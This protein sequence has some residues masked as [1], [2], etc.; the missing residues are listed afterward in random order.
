[1][2]V[3]DNMSDIDIA[4]KVKMKDIMVVAKSLGIE[5]DYL[6]VYGKY[7]AK[8]KFDEM[9]KSKNG[10]LILVTAI[11]PTP[12]GEGKTTV[13]IGLH[14]ALRRNGADSVAVLREPSLGPVFGMKGGATGGGYSQ[15]IPMEDINLHFTG[16]LHAITSANNLIS[17]AIDNHLHFGN[18]LGI[19]VSTITF[20]RCLDINDRALRD[21]VVSGFSEITRKE[22]FDITAASEVMSVFCLSK[23]LDDL[24]N[25]LGNIIVA[26]NTNGR[27]VYVKDLKL[28]GSLVV[29]LKDALNPNLVQ[30]LEN[31]PVII[32]GGPFANIAHGCNSII[33]TKLG[34]QLSDY[35]VTEAGFGADLGAEK[36]FDIKCRKAGLK[37][38]CVVLVATIRALKYNGGVD[39]NNINNENVEALKLGL[40][41]LLVHV[42]NLKKY[43]SNIIVALNRF[44]TDSEEE[45][46]IVKE[47]C[48]GLEINFTVST[49]Y[50][51]GGVGAVILANKVVD[52]CNKENDFK[53]LYDTYDSI[54][55]KIAII[56]KEIYHAGAVLYSDEALEKIKFIKELDLSHLPI[57]IAKTQYS[58]SDNPKLL[59]Y[60]KDFNVT[61]RDINLY[62]GAGFI[63]VI[64]GKIM[65]MPALP[66]S[67]NYE[68]IGLDHDNNIMG[69]F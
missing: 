45:V 36:F 19:D 47:C 58:I 31:N 14:D 8:I 34:L 67:P 43:T 59:G 37:P 12:Y 55:D 69:L 15:V 68:K 54:E 50:S 66:D 23:D 60:P 44:D 21:V 26:K 3:G 46:N 39:K 6:D 5:E 49:A 4:R 38:D 24:K 65:T 40:P 48:D 16:D 62:N 29:L 52:I 10:K 56:C 61:V 22:H 11:N 35:V 33:A 18:K 13:T 32:H 28:E 9:I 30:T 57:C 7:K 63:T 27:P 1:M 42:E 53:F 64:L 20:K 51:K 41:N 25:N 2:I 17:A